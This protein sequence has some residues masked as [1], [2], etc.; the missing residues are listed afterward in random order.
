M[1]YL[2]DEKGR[3]SSYKI[4]QKDDKIEGF[5]LINQFKGFE[6]KIKA[7]SVT[8]DH[9]LLAAV[10]EDG[11]CCQIFDFKTG[12]FIWKLTFSECVNQT[13]MKFVSCVFSLNWKFLYTLQSQK[14]TKTYL[15]KW[16]SE[17]GEFDKQ[18]TITVHKGPSNKMVFS[19][20]GF[21][22]AVVTD[23]LEVKSVNT[24]YM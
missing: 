3:V 7:I 23:D 17:D 22:L 20:E 24:R 6:N 12:A 15:T 4:I 2:G 19:S 18:H 13:N 5:E 11:E 14:G 16:E 1:F 21:Y 10:E 9:Q 8:H